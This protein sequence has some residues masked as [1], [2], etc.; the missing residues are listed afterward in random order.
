MKLHFLI[1]VALIFLLTT[2]S[3]V[4]AAP[5]Q[6]A[7]NLLDNP[8][9]ERPFPNGIADQWQNWFRN[10]P[11]DEK[12]AECL[13]G[14]HFR[15]KWNQESGNTDFI[16]EGFSAQYVGNNWDTWQGGVYQTVAVTPGIT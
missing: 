1:L 12:D 16:Y 14:Y 10:D 7:E 2:F 9:L 6:Q 13:N 3:A 15:P 4:R 5:R 8:S 11:A